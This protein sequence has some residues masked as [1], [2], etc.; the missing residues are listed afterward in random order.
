MLT[1]QTAGFTL[2]ELLTV[3]IVL[4]AI[5]AISLFNF[6]VSQLKARDA[7]RKAD[8]GAVTEALKRYNK[9]FGFFPAGQDGKVVA[10]GT[11]EQLLSCEWGEDKLV[12]LTDSS[13]PPYLAKF[14][15]DPQSKKG[16]AYI[17]LSNGAD[18]QLFAHLEGRKDT[19]RSQEVEAREIYCGSAICNF[20]L[21]SRGL[22][23]V[24][25]LKEYDQKE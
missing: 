1:K 19:E 11:P 23:P 10:C 20:G 5:G 9:D 13:Y 7:Q 16:L 14:P 22:L 15:V 17:Y 3:V 8:I 12:D 2:P 4:L 21:D 6:Q 25:D 24:K 18:F